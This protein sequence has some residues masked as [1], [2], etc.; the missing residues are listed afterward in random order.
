MLHPQVMSLNSIVEKQYEKHAPKYSDESQREE[1]S[2]PER[3]WLK[4]VS[5]TACVEKATYRKE[6]ML[7]R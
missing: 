1:N 5:P 6:G 4:K 7:K 2:H 3:Y